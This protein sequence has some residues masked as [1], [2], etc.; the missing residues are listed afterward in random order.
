MDRFGP[1]GKVSKKWSTFRPFF[2]VG[3][4]RSNWTV[5][6]DHSDSFSIPGPRCSESSMYKMEENTYHCTF[7]IVNSRSIGVTRTSM[8]SYHRSVAA[9]QAKCMFWLLTALKDDLFPERI[10]N[11]LFVI[12]FERGV[13]SHMANIWEQSAQNNPL[14]WLPINRQTD[15]SR[16]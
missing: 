6:F 9:S 1:T 5:P 4:V 14:Y 2:S 15:I 11:V 16:N 3:P 8:Y 13:W 12:R 7:W 10:W